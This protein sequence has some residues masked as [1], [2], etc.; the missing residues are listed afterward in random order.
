MCPN[1]LSGTKRINMIKLSDVKSADVIK[2]K[3]TLDEIIH[4]L[5][6]ETILLRAKPIKLN[7]KFAFLCWW[8]LG[9]KEKASEYLFNYREITNI[10]GGKIH[11]IAL[12][13]IAWKWVLENP[14]EARPFFE[15]DYAKLNRVLDDETWNRVLV[16]KAQ[17]VYKKY[18]ET[19]FE[20]FIKS[21]DFGRYANIFR[22]K[23]PRTAEK[24]L[25]EIYTGEVSA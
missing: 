20:F 6:P 2:G 9:S 25:N 24:Y 3:V 19:D 12:D 5:P 10:R 16:N 21:N 22:H 15:A 11:T 14:D 1:I 18:D 4:E 8:Y 23:K 17:V 13:K 7:P